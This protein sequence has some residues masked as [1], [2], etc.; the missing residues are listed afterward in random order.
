M[1]LE[2][3]RKTNKRAFIRSQKTRAPFI[4]ALA[5]SLTVTS[6]FNVIPLDLFTD[7]KTIHN[8]RIKNEKCA[9]K[10]TKWRKFNSR[11]SFQSY[12]EHREKFCIC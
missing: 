8:Y 6:Y 1:K 5:D 7:A 3:G 10:R 12:S 11:I 2:Q 9:G 4:K